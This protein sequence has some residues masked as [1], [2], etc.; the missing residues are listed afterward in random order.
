MRTKEQYYQD[1]I[2][3]RKILC[4]PKVTQ[5]TCPETLCTWHGNCKECVALHRYYKDHIPACLQP[6]L[7]DKLEALVGVCELK[8]TPKRGPKTEYKK[9]VQERDA[10]EAKGPKCPCL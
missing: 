9:Y 1:T 8:T 3:N 5:C 2:E 10:E 6:I 7:K 4:D